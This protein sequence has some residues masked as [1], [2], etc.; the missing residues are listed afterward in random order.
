MSGSHKN[1]LSSIA[2]AHHQLGP[3][4]I[5]F[6]PFKGR[7]ETSTRPDSPWQVSRVGQTANDLFSPTNEGPTG[8]WAFALSVPFHLTG[9]SPVRPN[10]LFPN[11][12]LLN[13]PQ[14]QLAIA[15]AEP[16]A[17]S[18]VPFTLKQE[19]ND[20]SLLR[21]SL[22]CKV[23]KSQSFRKRML[24]DIETRLFLLTLVAQTSVFPG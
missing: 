20:I 18:R 6:T 21:E 19:E 24:S 15:T 11:F 2:G 1:A 13:L 10:A 16:G 4:L 5:A 17:F 22:Q 3:C 12:N 23:D 14:G 7:G 9:S 8:K